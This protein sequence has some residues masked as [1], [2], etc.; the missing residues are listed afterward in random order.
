MVIFNNSSKTRCIPNDTNVFD[1][2][3]F[4]SAITDALS[5]DASQL[6]RLQCYLPV[7]NSVEKM[8]TFYD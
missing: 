6:E 3:V 5:I 8:N 7:F 4:Y 1:D 2:H